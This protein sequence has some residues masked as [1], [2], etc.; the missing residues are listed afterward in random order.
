MF[1]ALKRLL[2]EISFLFFPGIG[3]GF[4]LDLGANVRCSFG[5]IL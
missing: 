2:G 4:G 1:E 3:G 5:T